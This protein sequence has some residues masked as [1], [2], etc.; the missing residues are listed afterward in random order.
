MLVLYCPGDIVV[1]K[2]PHI[3]YE[4]FYNQNEYYE[5]PEYPQFKQ[6]KQPSAI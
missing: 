3:K 5:Q 1:T 4:A 2:K 6:M